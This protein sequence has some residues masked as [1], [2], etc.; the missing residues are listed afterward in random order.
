MYSSVKRFHGEVRR[1]TDGELRFTPR[2]MPYYAT[3]QAVTRGIYAIA[4]LRYSWG[5]A[6]ACLK[7]DRTDDHIAFAFIVPEE[8]T[9]GSREDDG[10]VLR[11]DVV[12]DGQVRA[13]VEGYALLA[14]VDI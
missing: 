9:A 10:V 1:P 11:D 12:D 5:Y 4:Q 6:C 2:L 3:V 8:S 7:I 13:V 14:V